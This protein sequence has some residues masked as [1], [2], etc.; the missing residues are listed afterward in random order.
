MK[1]GKVKK[2]KE[3]IKQYCSVCKETFDMEVV[4]NDD[5]RGGVPWLKCPGCEGFLPYMGEEDSDSGVDDHEDQQE[6][7][8]EDLSMEDRDNARVYEQTGE[9]KIDDIIYQRSWNDYGKVLE[10][11]VL[12]GGRKVIVVQFI[13]QGRMR[14]LEGAEQ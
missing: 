7:A 2:D 3:K 12:P 9:Y 1:K 6:L 5:D 10:K 8:P 11:Q 13:N 4:R 14:L